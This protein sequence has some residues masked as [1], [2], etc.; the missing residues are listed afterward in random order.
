M[1]YVKSPCAALD[2]RARFFLHIVPEAVEDLPA[3]RRSY[4]FDN[5]DFYYY[6]HGSMPL[7]LVRGK[8]I[9]ERRLPDYPIASVRTGQYTPGEGQIWKAEFPVRAVRGEAAARSAPG[10]APAR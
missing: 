8:C 6:D 1:T 3:D 7:L 2:T 9:V 10:K 5:L 4:G